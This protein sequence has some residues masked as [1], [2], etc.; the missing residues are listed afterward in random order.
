MPNPLFNSLGGNRPPINNNMLSQI[1]NEFNK[2]K[3]SF[4]GD[5]RA[6][7]QRLLNSGQMTQEQYNKL[8]QMAYQ[9]R[10]M[11]PH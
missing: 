1:M 2:F 9:L 5:P 7:V 4:T 3:S 10:N 11:F 8:S 6:E